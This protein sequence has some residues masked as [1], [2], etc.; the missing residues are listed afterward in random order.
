M[1]EYGGYPSDA[2]DLPVLSSVTPFPLE[3]KRVS[4]QIFGLPARRIR[5][6]AYL[7]PALSKYPG[8]TFPRLKIASRHSYYSSLYTFKFIK[9]NVYESFYCRNV[10]NHPPL[11]TFPTEKHI[12]ACEPVYRSSGG[13]RNKLS[14]WR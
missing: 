6:T 3:L 1:G 5:A 11:M 14:K 10:Q 9:I 2:N 12:E 7:I 4:L 8:I 13:V